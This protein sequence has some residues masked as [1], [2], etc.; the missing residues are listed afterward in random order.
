MISRSHCYFH[1]FTQ[2]F[3]FQVLQIINV[4][5]CHYHYPKTPKR[6]IFPLD[7]HFAIVPRFLRFHNVLID[8]LHT[9]MASKSIPIAKRCKLLMTM[10]RQFSSAFQGCSLTFQSEIGPSCASLIF[11][12]SCSHFKNYTDHLAYIKLIALLFDRCSSYYFGTG[13]V[14]PICWCAHPIG[15]IDIA[16]LLAID[17]IKKC[18]DV[19]I[20]Q[21][22]GMRVKCRAPAT[23][24]PTRKSCKSV[25]QKY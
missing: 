21:N 15:S 5:R 17:S 13:I 8:L 12:Q 3:N 18:S 22:G 10:L 19:K 16:G 9:N 1:H 11:K 24:F 20:Q 14:E 7:Y 25:S 23:Q 2:W 6:Q 4:N